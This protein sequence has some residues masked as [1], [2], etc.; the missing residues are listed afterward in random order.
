[1]LDILYLAIMSKKNIALVAGGYTGEYEVSI[2]S[3]KN[4]AA[5][6]PADQFNV[7]TIL[8]NRD[9]WFHEAE[10]GKVNVD[11]NDFSIT[12]DGEKITFDAAFITVHGTPGEDGKL[13]GYFDM[14]G[15]PY[16]T[17]DA[18][19]S[20]I[21]MNKAYTKT[22]VHG[23]KN[24]NAAKSMRLFKADLHDIGTISAALKF[25]LFIKPN[26][27]GSSVGMSKVNKAAE[28]PHAL[29]KAFKEDSQVL[30]E[31]FIKGR[32]FSIGIARLNHHLTVLPATEIISSKEFFDYEAKYTPGVSEEI[33]PAN[34]TPEQNEMIAEIVT[35]VYLRFNCKGMVRVDFILQEQTNDFYFIEV[36]TTPGQ[37]ASSLIPQQ[38][39]AAGMDIKQFYSDIINGAATS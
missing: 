34:L 16:N 4:I 17:C 1:L 25:P 31:E 6:L 5:N 8:L 15:L 20:A 14:L 7:Y 35:E 37:S 27:G 38:V 18:A 9:S 2:N 13:Q 33:T 39:K 10:S 26:N 19:T 21:T 30:V 11:K 22:I 23:I 36:N 32:E 12:I 29:E 3:A 28:L 24:L